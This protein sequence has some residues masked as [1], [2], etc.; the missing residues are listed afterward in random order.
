[1]TIPPIL[2]RTVLG[3][4]V[5]NQGETSSFVVDPMATQ[6]MLGGMWR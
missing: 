3:T 2:C 5:G 6:E 1:M 4:A